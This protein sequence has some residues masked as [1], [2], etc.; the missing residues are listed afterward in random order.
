M[1]TPEGNLS[2]HIGCGAAVEIREYSAARCSNGTPPVL[3]PAGA[4]DNITHVRFGSNPAVAAAGCPTPALGRRLALA[5]V[6]NERLLIDVVHC[7]P[8]VPVSAKTG[9]Q[10]WRIQ[11]ASPCARQ[12]STDGPCKAN[13]QPS[14]DHLIGPVTAKLCVLAM[15]RDFVA[16]GNKAGP[17]H[18][19]PQKG[20]QAQDWR[21]DR[22]KPLLR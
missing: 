10:H 14:G 11:R 15:S 8:A 12:P 19:G 17:A 3:R 18:S 9:H 22:C 13:P 21:R 16:G 7:K 5:I 4:G 20:Y 1:V 6:M 2:Q